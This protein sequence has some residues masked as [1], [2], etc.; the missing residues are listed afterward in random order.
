MAGLRRASVIIHRTWVRMRWRSQ[1]RVAMRWRRV[2]RI[3]TGN[4]HPKW[5]SMRP[6]DCGRGTVL[7]IDW[8]TAALLRERRR[9]SQVRIGRMSGHKSGGVGRDGREDAFLLEPLAVGTPSIFGGF[10][11]RAANLRRISLV[12]QGSPIPRPADLAS[13]AIATGNGCALPWCWLMLGIHVMGRWRSTM[14]ILRMAWIH[15]ILRMAVIIRR[16]LM[17]GRR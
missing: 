1:G 15:I 10:E 2:I 16:R 12:F 17:L 14:R 11:A 9:I 5:L 3:L 13:S 4:R 8:S 7:R 6:V